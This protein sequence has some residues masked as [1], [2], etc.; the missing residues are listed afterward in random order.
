[1][2]IQNKGVLQGQAEQIRDE[3]IDNANTATRVGSH[4]L[5]E[6]ATIN[7]AGFAT[8]ITGGDIT[9]ANA[10][11]QF[12]IG[13]G[14]VLTDLRG[15]PLGMQYAAD[16]SSTYTDRSIPDWKAVTDAIQAIS[17]DL[18]DLGDVDLAG[19]STNQIIE[20]NGSK[21]VPITTPSGG[22]GTQT[23]QDVT[24]LGHTTT[25]DI[26]IKDIS[27][28]KRLD[29]EGDTATLE[30]TSPSSSAG[31]YATFQCRNDGDVTDR[32]AFAIHSSG[33][34]GNSGAGVALS[35][36]GKIQKYGTGNL[37]IETDDGNSSIGNK[38]DGVIFSVIQG[39][40]TR[41]SGNT[42]DWDFSVD[43]NGHLIVSGP[44]NANTHFSGD[45]VAYSSASPPAA[46][47]W[48]DL[49]IAS[50]SQHGGI[51]V[52]SGLTMTAG[53]LSATGGGV[54]D[55]GALTGLGDDD[56][57][58]YHNDTRGDARYS[59]LAHNHSG[60]YLPVAADLQD[61]TD[62]G[63]STT[64]PMTVIASGNNIFVYDAAN[65]GGVILK[66][67]VANVNGSILG[68]NGSSYCDLVLRTGSNLDNGIYIQ[69]DSYVGMG[70]AQPDNPVHVDND[71][72]QIK[73]Q[74]NGASHYCTLGAGTGF[75]VMDIRNVTGGVLDIRKNGVN[76]LTIESDGDVTCVADIRAAGEVTAYSTS[77]KRL[78]SGVETLDT[79]KELSNIKA[80]RPVKYYHKTH[81]QEELG[82]IAQEVQEVLPEITKVKPT[83]GMI[84][85][86]Y[87][88]VVPSLVA[89]IQQLEKRI[90]QLEKKLWQQ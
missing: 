39:G 78:K 89:S 63:A 20:W 69:T 35:N 16:Y 76:Q 73:L 23:L 11:F 61:V 72:P 70:T 52:G 48:D 32:F 41:M 60:T 33:Y 82:L 3:T 18:G 65:T 10:T 44:T 37:S 67:D 64:N 54:T 85:I 12:Q 17:L 77:D 45:V 27:S 42:Y 21:W 59:L 50:A 25:N 14:L 19:L 9:L 4:L 26:F 75:T 86:D 80:L 57:T 62:N 47:W 79:R 81:K 8:S 88:R 58:Q 22:G 53:V 66:P 30:V 5:T 43:S 1:M 28:A 13:T 15:T 46:S 24:D 31:K 40:I 83:D 38:N 74:N 49:P 51:K 56:H 71:Y 87:A 2:S 36:L 55:H 84:M 6:A 29:L 90:K 7:S 34:A 68:H